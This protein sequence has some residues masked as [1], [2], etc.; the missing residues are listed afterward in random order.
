M[1]IAPHIYI[2]R[3]EIIKKKKKKKTSQVYNVHTLY[4]TVPELRLRNVILIC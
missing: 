3:H 4:T 1:E 2:L